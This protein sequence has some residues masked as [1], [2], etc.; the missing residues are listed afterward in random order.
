MSNDNRLIWEENFNKKELE[1]G[2]YYNAEIISENESN[3]VA[4]GRRRAEDD[5]SPMRNTSIDRGSLTLTVDQL[6]ANETYRFTAKAR[7]DDEKT[8]LWVGVV[9]FENELYHVPKDVHEIV[10]STDWVDVSV[11]LST[12]PRTTEVAFYGLVEGQAGLAYLKEMKVYKVG[13]TESKG[14]VIE[15]EGIELGDT[16]NEFP[17]TIP[18]VQTFVPNDS[19]WSLK[20]KGQII[21]NLEDK[22]VIFETAQLLKKELKSDPKLDANFEITYGDPKDARSGDIILVLGE[23]D[24]PELNDTDNH[25]EREAYQIEIKKGRLTLTS[26]TNL[27]IFYGTRT[28]LQALQIDDYLPGGL[29]FDWPFD[30][31]RGLQVDT[32]RRYFSIDWLKAQIRDLAW[33]KMNTLHI[34]LKDSNGLRYES[35]VAPD[36][37]SP[38]YYKKEEIKELVEYAK[39]YHVTII[40]EIDT[41]GHSEMDVLVYPEF[42]LKKADGSLINALDFTKPEVVEYVQKLIAEVIELFDPPYIHLG[43]DEYENSDKDA[44]HLLE[45]AKEKFGPDATWYDGYRDYFNQLAAPLLEQGITPVVWND[46]FNPGDGVV[47]LDKQIIIDYW[48]KWDQSPLVGEFHKAGYQT[49]NKNSDWLYY[50]LWPKFIGGDNPRRFPENIYDVWE[51]DAYMKKAAWGKPVVRPRDDHTDYQDSAS[52]LHLGAM[53]AIWDDPHGWPSEE[54]VTKGMLHRLRAY[55]QKA[56]GSNFIAETYAAFDHYV[57]RIGYSIEVPGK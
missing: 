12:G 50:D 29:V 23:L 56:W 28:I 55:N 24:E 35:D 13:V 9:D 10:S 43:G 1:A 40:P 37:V 2:T 36:L 21:I 47:E 25:I 14:V 22:D 57:D 3:N 27:G 15:P 48:A 31:V 30:K 52:S 49:I 34:R 41:P 6:E 20:N 54:W 8:K 53:F 11:D 51:T 4:I 17:L 26:Q 5:P 7:V 42:G 16:G 18:A 38:E 44:P 32:A 46:M 33:T 45:W 19:E 39:R